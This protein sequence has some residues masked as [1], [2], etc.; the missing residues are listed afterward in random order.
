MDSEDLACIRC[1]AQ[2]DHTALET[3]YTRYRPR[4]YRFLWQ[5][6]GGDATLIEEVLQ[7]T[8]LAVWRGAATFRGDARVAS[9]IF[10]IA[11][12]HAH[13]A[14]RG[15]ARQEGRTR[16]LSTLADDADLPA[17]PEHEDHTLT[18]LALQDALTRL[19]DKQRVVVMLVFVQG[20]TG[21]ETADILGLPLGTVKSRLRAARSLLA[22]DPA[23]H[24][25]EEVSS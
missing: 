16:S 8:F 2:G 3:L 21:E 19:S 1:I 5:Q 10:R 9:W 17:A 11:L 24:Q 20:F 6:V 14:Q 18:R 13:H 4:L 25:S 15:A 23:L 12:H 22:N 7:D